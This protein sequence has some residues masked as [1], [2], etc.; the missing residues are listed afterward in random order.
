M[1]NATPEMIEARERMY[2][3]QIKLDNLD[4]YGDDDD[5]EYWKRR[6]FIL[7]RWQKA[8]D[9]CG[10]DHHDNAFQ[11]EETGKSGRCATSAERTRICQFQIDL[12]DK[13]DGSQKKR[14]RWV[15]R[16]GRHQRDARIDFQI[17]Q[18]KIESTSER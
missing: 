4:C 2:E 1:S 16:L 7:D 9:V 12:I 11:G 3:W 13:E 15:T 10:L 6:E 17:Q 14:Q 18:G 8:T 5:D